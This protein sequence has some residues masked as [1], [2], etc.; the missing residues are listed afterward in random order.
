VSGLPSKGGLRNEPQGQGSSSLSCCC[1]AHHP[2]ARPQVRPAARPGPAAVLCASCSNRS[3][4]SKP[5]IVPDRS[6]LPAPSEDSMKDDGIR[7]SDNEEEERAN[8]RSYTGNF[9]SSPVYDTIW[10]R[11]PTIPP[12]CPT[13]SILPATSVL[14]AMAT[15]YS[16]DGLDCDRCQVHYSPRL[17]RW[18]YARARRRGRR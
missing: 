5:V 8:G 1:T 9:F 16:M 14:M 13:P 15:F 12:T 10:W 6:D 17:S 7:E 11:A 2:P 18:C 4:F 3:L